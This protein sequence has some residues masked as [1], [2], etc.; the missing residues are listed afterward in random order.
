MELFSF[1]NF[2][3]LFISSTIPAIIAYTRFYDKTISKLFKYFFNKEFPTVSSMLNCPLCFS[4]TFGF[5]YYCI[6]WGWA[7][8]FALAYASLNAICSFI[9]YTLFDF[10][11][12]K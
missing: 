2:I 3:W 8:K 1:D 12:N 9:I 6:C 5:I 11:E 7:F 10:L 4:W